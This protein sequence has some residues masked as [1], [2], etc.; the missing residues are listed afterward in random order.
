MHAPTGQ[1]VDR[2]MDKLAKHGLAGHKSGN[3]I[4]TMITVQ[5]EMKEAIIEHFERLPG[6]E[7]IITITTPYK[8]VSRVLHPQTSQI[9]IGDAIFGS[10]QIPVIAG[11]CAIES[12]DQLY[13]TALAVKTAGASILRAGAFKPRT[14]PYSFQGLQQEGLDILKEVSRKVNMPAVSEVTDPRLVEVV[15]QS[16]DILQIGARNMQNYALLQ[17]AAHTN[18]PIMLKR[19]PSATIEEWLMAAEYILV[20]GNDKVILCERG[21]RT[22]ETATRNTL[23][24]NAVAVVKQWSHL[25]VIVD[26]SHGTG[27]WSLVNPLA[28]AA[29]AAGADGIMVEVHPWP[30]EA[31]SDGRQSLTPDNFTTLINQLSPIA[32]ALDKFI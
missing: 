23:D 10:A 25:P 15:S 1:Q 17:E 8:L 22:F 5:G 9:A 18:K 29:I 13:Q 19:G 12:Y 26:P 2:I 30:E 32:K 16:V 14:S 20:N 31:L 7:R 27:V 11:P 4:R 21:I 28:K 24:L 6:V 3:S